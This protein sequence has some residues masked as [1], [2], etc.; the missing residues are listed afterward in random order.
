MPDSFEAKLKQLLQYGDPP[1]DEA[2]VM[3]VMHSVKR[4]Q[5]TRRTILWVFGLVGALFGVS[6][7]MMLSGPV[8][9]LLSGGMGLPV[10]E[11]MQATLFIVG[12]AAF[13]LW[14]MNDD[15]SLGE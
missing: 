8:G 5:R 10:T 14:F 12:A 3:D 2:F 15:F 13:Y 1:N 6:G 9:G 11:T 4:Q 7:A